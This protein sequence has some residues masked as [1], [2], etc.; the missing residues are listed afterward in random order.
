[1]NTGANVMGALGAILVPWFAGTFS[2]T[3]AIASGGIFALIGAVLLL[4]VRADGRVFAQP[5]P[6]CIISDFG[7]L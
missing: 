7:V 2:W 4:F 5:C 1:M 6:F 3:F